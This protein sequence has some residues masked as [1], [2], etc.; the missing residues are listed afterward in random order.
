MS[1]WSSS[2]SAASESVAKNQASDRSLW[3]LP[4]WTRI[5]SRTCIIGA[6]RGIEITLGD[7]LLP[8]LRRNAQ[9]G[10]EVMP[11]TAPGLRTSMALCS[12]PVAPLAASSIR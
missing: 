12:R 2:T 1:G 9:G 11:I 6:L 8:G 7:C 10:L 4:A 3:H 5:G